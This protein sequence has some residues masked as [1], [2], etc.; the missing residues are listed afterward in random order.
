M[1]NEYCYWILPGEEGDFMAFCSS[2]G[3][4]DLVKDLLT[5]LKHAILMRSMEKE[6]QGLCC[7]SS[8]FPDVLSL[9][10]LVYLRVEINVQ[11][12][13]N[14]FLSVLHVATLTKV[15]ITQLPLSE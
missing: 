1:R 15:I 5:P 7:D 14:A 3:F 12:Y 8:F 2:L 6:V 9:S 13:G 11:G 10:L 4:Q